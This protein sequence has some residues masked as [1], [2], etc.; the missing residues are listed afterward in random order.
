MKSRR[1]HSSA[2][3]SLA[4]DD[5]FILSGSED[6]TL[7]VFDRRAAAV[8][9]RL[10]VRPRY[11]AP[12]GEGHLL[13]RGREFTDASWLVGKEPNEQGPLTQLVGGGGGGGQDS[14][15]SSPAL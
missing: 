4:A 7:V 6:R 10:Q 12:G 3:L 8:L 15:V 2:V 13:L 14:W 11:L 9:Q 5:R 1:L